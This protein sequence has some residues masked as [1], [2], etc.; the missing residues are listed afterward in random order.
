MEKS[1]IKN[2]IDIYHGLSN[3]I[4]RIKTHN[5]PYV[6]TIHDLIFLK[7]TPEIIETLIGRSIIQN[8]NMP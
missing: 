6:V 1:I 4:P 7:D 3:E 2:E 5:I 8:S